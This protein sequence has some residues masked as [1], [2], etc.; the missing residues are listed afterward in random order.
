MMKFKE[1]LVL[2]FESEVYAIENSRTF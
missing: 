1:L 2:L